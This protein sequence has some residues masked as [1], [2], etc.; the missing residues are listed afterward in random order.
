MFGSQDAYTRGK[1][2]AMVYFMSY[3]L[4]LILDDYEGENRDA[5]VELF[6]ERI[7]WHRNMVATAVKGV[8]NLNTLKAVSLSSVQWRA[9]YIQ[10]NSPL[11]P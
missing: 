6:Q 7:D 3:V 2:D 5:I 11:S 10:M 9:H 4:E 8:V 1:V